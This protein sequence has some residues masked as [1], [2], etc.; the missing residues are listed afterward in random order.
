MTK[1]NEHLETELVCMLEI[2][3]ECEKAKDMQTQFS[4]QAKFLKMKLQKE[5]DIIGSSL[6]K[7]W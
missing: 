3:K 6:E 2:H 4:N 5:K 7:L 1:R